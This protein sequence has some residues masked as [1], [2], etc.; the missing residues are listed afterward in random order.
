MRNVVST[1]S[2]CEFEAIEMYSECYARLVG[3][4]GMSCEM[5]LSRLI[6]EGIG[7]RVN[8]CGDDRRLGYLRWRF[9]PCVAWDLR[10][11]VAR[12]CPCGSSGYGT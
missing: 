8:H 4:V 10:R 1:E 3:W 5:S 12:K 11:D 9:W 2:R 6:E 7:F